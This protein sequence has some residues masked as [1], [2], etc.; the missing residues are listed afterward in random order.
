MLYVN[1][2]VNFYL[3][4]KSETIEPTKVGSKTLKVGSI[5]SNQ[6]RIYT[7]LLKKRSW[8]P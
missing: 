8:T 5:I 2:S 1:T 4:I 6:R 7:N 3:K